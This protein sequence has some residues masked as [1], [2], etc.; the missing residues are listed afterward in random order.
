MERAL[1]LDRGGW[2]SSAPRLE[3]PAPAGGQ[4]SGSGHEL[5]RHPGPWV[6]R[7]VDVLGFRSN[8]RLGIQETSRRRPPDSGA[9]AVESCPEGVATHQPRATPW[10]T[11]DSPSTRAL[12]GRHKGNP[13]QLVLA[14][15]G[16]GVSWSPGPRFAPNGFALR[17]CGSCFPLVTN[18]RRAL[19]PHWVYNPD[20]NGDDA[21]NRR[22]QI[23]MRT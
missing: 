9:D 23:D 21:C 10:E 6:G 3:K 22:I 14:L 19:S 18:R 12:K 20:S 2:K 7:L 15:S 16:L 4:V 17:P 13:G 11:R 5:F 8:I 1:P